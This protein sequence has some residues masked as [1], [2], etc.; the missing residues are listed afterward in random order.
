MRLDHLLSKEQLRNPSLHSR[1]GDFHKMK[2]GFQFLVD[3][4]VT[5]SVTL[6]R[7]GAGETDWTRCL[8]VKE[9]DSLSAFGIQDRVEFRLGRTRPFSHFLVT[10]WRR[11]AGLPA[12]GF[13]RTA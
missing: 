2:E 13:L 4:L 11:L 7:K 3:M 12:A 5:Q 6:P 1:M 8:A 10:T 9:P